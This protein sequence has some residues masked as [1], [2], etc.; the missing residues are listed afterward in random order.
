[1][2]W[3]Q[4]WHLSG[5]YLAAAV[6]SELMHDLWKRVVITTKDVEKLVR[7]AYEGLVVYDIFFSLWYKIIIIILLWLTGEQ[8]VFWLVLLSCV[9]ILTM[10]LSHHSLSHK[11][12]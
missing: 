7:P 1:M 2:V 9:F 12:V 8:K 5:K 6:S 4:I 3:Y 10:S 11:K